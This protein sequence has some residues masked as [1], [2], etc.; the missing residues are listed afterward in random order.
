MKPHISIILFLFLSFFIF[1][2]LI[3]AQVFE[4]STKE[5]TKEST[6][7][8]VGKC[9][10]K[11]SFWND[12]QDKIFTRVRI[13]V[14]KTIKGDISGETE[15]LIPGGRV[16]NIIYEVSDMPAFSEGEESV[17]FLW[18]HT[19]GNNLVTGALHGKLKIY[20]DKA[21]GKKA[22][23]GERDHEKPDVKQKSELRLLKDFVEEIKSYIKE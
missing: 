18:K 8:V 9:V 3:F 14:D 20:T 23:K 12:K 10:E 5:L 15:I 7:I 6:A 21:S 19:S 16:G 22:V 17:V 1:P 11:K 4:M 13:N 2:A